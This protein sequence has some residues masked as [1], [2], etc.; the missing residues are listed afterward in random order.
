MRAI[1]AGLKM[2]VRAGIRHVFGIPAGSINALYDAFHEST[3]AIAVADKLSGHGQP[4]MP[5]VAGLD[6][7]NYFAD[8]V[9]PYYRFARSIWHRSGLSWLNAK[10]H[11][12]M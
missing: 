8:R 4:P 5:V 6:R 7:F 11:H 9:R 1:E 10:L 3:A 12:R 2:L